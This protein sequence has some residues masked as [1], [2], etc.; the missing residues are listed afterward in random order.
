MGFIEQEVK[1]K[2]RRRIKQAQTRDELEK[3]I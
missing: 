2:E 1:L 3:Q